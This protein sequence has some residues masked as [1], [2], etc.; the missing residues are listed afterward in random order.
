MTLPSSLLHFIEAPEPLVEAGAILPRLVKVLSAIEQIAAIENIPESGQLKVWINACQQLSACAVQHREARSSDPLRG[1]YEQHQAFVSLWHKPA[2]PLLAGKHNHLLAHLL[3]A[4]SA[5]REIEAAGDHFESS[6][7]TAF[8]FA[9]SICKS[10]YATTLE[11][12]PDKACS[13]R[14]YLTH[15]EGLNGSPRSAAFAV[16]IRYALGLRKSITRDT[17]DSHLKFSARDP[18]SLDEEPD[19]FQEHASIRS[20]QMPILSPAKEREIERSGLSQHEFNHQKELSQTSFDQDRPLDGRRS[21]EHMYRAK[22]SQKKI[23]MS[24]QQLQSRWSVLT[25]FEASAV[26]NGIVSTYRKSRASKDED[27]SGQTL[28]LA[29]LLTI[30][31]WFSIPLDEAIKSIGQERHPTSPKARVEFVLAHPLCVLVKT[32]SPEYRSQYKRYKRLDIASHVPLNSGIGIEKIIADHFTRSDKRQ[33]LFDKSEEYYSDLIKDF[34]ASLN[35]KYGCRLTSMRIA[36]YMF[37]AIANAP[38]S[39]LTYAML[40]T[41]QPSYNGANALFYTAVSTKALNDIYRSACKSIAKSA[42]LELSDDKKKK[43]SDSKF[44]LEDRM[45]GSRIRPTHDDVGALCRDLSGRIKRAKKEGPIEVHNAMAIY[46]SAFINFSTGYRS[47]G[48]AS[49]HSDEIDYQTGFAVISDKDSV[50]EYHSRLIWIMPE[51]IEQIRNYRAQLKVV[52]EHVSLTTHDIY[53]ELSSEL[54]GG[55]EGKTSS[56]PGLFIIRD[57]KIAAL[58]P[59]IY[60]ASFPRSYPYPANAHRHYL[61]S[62]LLETGCPSDVVNA[63]MG[64]WERGQEPWSSYSSLGPIEY[65]DAIKPILIELVVERCGWR[66]IN[67]YA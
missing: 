39:D 50:D 24:N 36:R 19:H 3:I 27:L 45:H 5:C 23:A 44:T 63:L 30:I 67:P 6:R 21:V 9:R 32:A 28:E 61:R 42:R 62:N 65:R 41:G 34:I 29:A 22:S 54:L 48:D 25:S 18:A 46:T 56:M 55:D 60:E 53:T 7:K 10:S 14:E 52:L 26:A 13:S 2:D 40:I 11:S 31:F 4:N 66:A 59:S 35:Q 51:C 20:I 64:H 38:R 15:L 47:V 16:F 43:V 37:E 17:N 1:L 12:L 49:F 58:T 57:K 33:K 8:T